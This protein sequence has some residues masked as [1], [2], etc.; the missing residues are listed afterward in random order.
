MLSLY[1]L[2]GILSHSK[3]KEI[4]LE[5]QDPEAPLNVAADH[6][7][8]IVFF[9]Q[10]KKTN[11]I[12]YEVVTVVL[13]SMT[14]KTEKCELALSFSEEKVVPVLVGNCYI[15]T[16]ANHLR[17][18]DQISIFVPDIVHFQHLCLYKIYIV[19]PSH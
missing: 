17:I 7:S 2:G 4:C 8:M 14:P 9:F 13:D 1:H 16:L 6:E 18:Y 5:K 15:A 10:I 3:K 12:C 19:Y 11:Q